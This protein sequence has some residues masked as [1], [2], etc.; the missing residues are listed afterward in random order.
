M[1]IR[2]KSVTLTVAVF[3]KYPQAGRVK[4]RLEP[5]LGADQCAEFARYLLLSTLDKLHGVN[6][7]LWT[8][9]GTD[10]RMGR[11]ASKRVNFPAMFSGMFN[12][13]GIWAYAWNVRSANAFERIPCGG[14][15]GT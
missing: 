4:T 5:L 3:A 1:Q 15:A 7:A 11:F 2:E 10:D 12:P 6:V 9:G 13:L 8:D 14:I